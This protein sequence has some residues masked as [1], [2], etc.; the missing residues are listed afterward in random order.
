MREFLPSALDPGV[1]SASNKN[2]N[3]QQK[4]NEISE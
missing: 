3:H 1:L 4:N 2:E